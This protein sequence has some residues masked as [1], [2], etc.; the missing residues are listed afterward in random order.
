M[1][2]VHDA[3]IDGEYVRLVAVD[4]LSRFVSMR[5]GRLPGP[6]EQSRCEVL[7]VG[8][9][10]RPHLREGGIDLV[11]TGI[12]TVP[13]P[14]ALG[15]AFEGLHTYGT[16]EGV[17]SPVV[18]LTADVHVDEKRKTLS[19]TDYLTKPVDLKH[20]CSVIDRVLAEH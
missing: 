13:E 15:P 16:Q 4:G 6:C 5:D 12:A 20:L 17:R 10:G 8:D 18:L 7:Q 14:R 1:S 2:F 11:R 19:A 3:L 9:V